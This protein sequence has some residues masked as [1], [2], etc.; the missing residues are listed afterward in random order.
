MRIVQVG[1]QNGVW[2]GGW[3][4]GCVCVRVKGVRLAGAFVVGAVSGCNNN[5]GVSGRVTDSEAAQGS[6]G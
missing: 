6:F 1:L 3:V 5:S 2:V 4:P